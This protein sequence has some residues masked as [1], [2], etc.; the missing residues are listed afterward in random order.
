MVVTGSPDH[1]TIRFPRTGHIW[2]P[3][4]PRRA[5]ASGVAMHS[6][7]QPVK[8]A[9][10]RALYLAVRVFG[11][12]VIPGERDDWHDPL[13]RD[14]WDDLLRVWAAEVGT[15]D[16][17]V[18]Y[19][20]PQA[21]RVGFAALL[22]RGGTG[23][24]F[25]RF[26]PDPD[27]IEREFGV[28]QGIHSAR[29]SSFSVAKPLATGTTGGD[30]G[31]L[32]SE[33]LPNYPL[34]AVRKPETRARV[35]GEVSDVLAGFMKRPE[36]V[37]AHW[38][39]AHGDFAPWN[40]RTLIS[41]GVRVIDWE[42]AGF[43]PPGVDLLYGALTAHTTFNSPLPQQAGAEAIEWV[44]DRIAN[45]GHNGVSEPD[46]VMLDSLAGLART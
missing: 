42:D 31:W 7:C 1:R 14:E 29:P 39:P 20:R 16:Q 10:Q 46:R 40:L 4:T 2:I 28:L 32:L 26:H 9:A 38:L 13:P 36:G 43:A 5:A 30:G 8:V 23:V 34:G 11:G 12:R 19:R 35:A 21:G 17:L 3:P 22:L 41:G 18:L 25:A 33:S 45:R 37:P 44:T 27:R 24:A 6:P 15:F